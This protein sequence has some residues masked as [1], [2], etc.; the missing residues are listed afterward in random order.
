MPAARA[1]PCASA[2]VDRIESNRIDAR[3]RSTLRRAT[4]A[5]D[6]RDA[7]RRGDDEEVAMDEVRARATPRRRRWT[8]E[9]CET[10][11]RRDRDARERD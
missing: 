7:P 11:R 5:M 1:S 4:D 6:A 8:N 9:R 3:L 10:R 2:R